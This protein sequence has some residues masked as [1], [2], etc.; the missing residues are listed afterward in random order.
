MAKPMTPEQLKKKKDDA[1]LILAL[2]FD[3]A[4][5]IAGGIHADR[6]FQKA[7]EFIGSAEKRGYKIEDVFSPISGG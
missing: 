3:V 6:A 4:G 2:L 1:R 5:T 7:D